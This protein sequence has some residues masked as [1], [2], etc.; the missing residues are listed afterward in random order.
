MVLQLTLEEFKSG[1]RPNDGGKVV[2]DGKRGISEEVTSNKI[3][4]I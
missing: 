3:S 1:L 4:E 2:P